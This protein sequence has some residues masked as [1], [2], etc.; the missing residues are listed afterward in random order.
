M[1]N[2]KNKI[3]PEKLM[4]FDWEKDKDNNN[5]TKIGK[6]DFERIKKLFDG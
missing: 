6:K 4:K 1:P 2:L 5:V 3:S